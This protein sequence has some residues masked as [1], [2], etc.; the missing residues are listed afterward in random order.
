VPYKGGGPLITDLLGGHLNIVLG[1]LP[2]YEPHE[3]TGKMKAI[4]VLTKTRVPQWPDLQTASETLPGF[5]G[6]T[7]FGLLAPGGT[8][9]D[10]VARLQRDVA[11]ALND[12]KIKEE[13][14]GKGFD[15]VASTPDAF[16]AFLREQSNGAGR[17]VRDAGIKPE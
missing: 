6:G 11:K 13:L 8:P 7:W 3:K 16:G 5:E 1:T 12:P 9:K 2:L 4:A 17:L 14:A 10:L 15:V